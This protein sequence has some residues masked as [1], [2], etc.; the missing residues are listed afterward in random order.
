VEERVQRRVQ[1]LSTTST[2]IASLYRLDKVPAEDEVQADGVICNCFAD[3][4][5]EDFVQAEKWTGRP[6]RGVLAIDKVEAAQSSLE[7]RMLER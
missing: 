6:L 5:A 2:Q 4:K 3:A 1:R 7:T